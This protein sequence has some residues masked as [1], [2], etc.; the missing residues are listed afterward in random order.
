MT[1]SDPE[2]L[3]HIEPSELNGMEHSDIYRYFYNGELRL[4]PDEIDDGK[5]LSD[6]QMDALVA[7]DDSDLTG[8]LRLIWVEFHRL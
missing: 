1:D 6:Q 3:F 8:I 5:W 2:Y 7:S 4:Q